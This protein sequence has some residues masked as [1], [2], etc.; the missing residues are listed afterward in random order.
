MV[1]D[2]IELQVGM[3][4]RLLDDLSNDN[5]GVAEAEYD[6]NPEMQEMG[7]EVLTITGFGMGNRPN[8][9]YFRCEENS[10]AWYDYCIAELFGH[11][12]EDGYIVISLND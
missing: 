3:K 10:W 1:F 12:T 11:R 8:R 9:P 6:V 5:I 4:V 2:G 7:G